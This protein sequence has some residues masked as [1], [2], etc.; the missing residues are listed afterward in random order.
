MVLLAPVA[1]V[2]ALVSSQ[3]GFN[4]HVHY[5]LPIFPFAFVWTSKVARAIDR[6]HRNIATP[7]AG[8]LLWS[9]ASSLWCYPHSLSCFNELVG[10]PKHG[11]EHLLD[12]NI[13]RGQDLLYLKR[14]VE[15]HPDA[16]PLGLAY[17]LPFLD[18][19]IAGMEYT[20]PPSGPD[21][22]H[23]AQAGS[24]DRNR[25]WSGGYLD[26]AKPSELG[27]LRG[28]GRI[29]PSAVD[30]AHFPQSLWSVAPVRCRIEH[31]ND[32]RP[33]DSIAPV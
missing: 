20:L 19:R 1:A 24:P 26:P 28:R 29:S 11:H 31:R 21:C 9:V 16:R 17:C 7:A 13:D 22:K 15:E 6:R 8:A 30:S 12:S 4:H 2:L 3:T 5:V 10:G 18:P 32:A 33:G 27:N 25:G 14:W 23:G